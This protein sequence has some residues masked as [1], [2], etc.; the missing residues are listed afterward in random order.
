M[1]LDQIKIDIQKRC[2]EL[3]RHHLNQYG[4]EQANEDAYFEAYRTK[5]FP[6]ELQCLRE[7]VHTN[8]QQNLERDLAETKLLFLLVGLSREPGLLV[9]CLHQP[10][11]AVLIH[12]VGVDSSERIAQDLQSAIEEVFDEGII[13]GTCPEISPLTIDASNPEA[14]CRTIVNEWEVGWKS[15]YAKEH[16]AIDITGGKNTMVAGAYLAAEETGL[17]T[18]YLD[19]D[20]YDTI[21]RLPRPAT[22][23]YRRFPK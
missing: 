3:R 5:I 17:K 1:N 12:T 4:R 14:V 16:V 8:P 22:Y 2:S 19:F 15:R 9:T 18:Y 20:E 13:E 7:R 23:Q 10:E 21:F 11:H 6:D